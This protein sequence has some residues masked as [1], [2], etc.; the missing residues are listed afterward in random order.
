[1]PRKPDFGVAPRLV[2]L[3]R[4]VDRVN[5]LALPASDAEVFESAT[6][7]KPRGA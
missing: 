7:S 4:L 3:M 6:N 2:R 1:M 5:G